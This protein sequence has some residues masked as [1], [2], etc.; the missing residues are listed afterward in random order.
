MLDAGFY[1]VNYPGNP[2][3]PRAYPRR[4]LLEKIGIK[5]LLK[6]MENIED[7]SCYFKECL[8]YFDGKILKKFYGMSS[9][10]LSKEIRGIDTEIN[11]QNYGMFLFHKIA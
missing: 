6:K 7:R 4:E 2:L 1:I 11:G 10:S 9:G 5:G 8:A 3:F